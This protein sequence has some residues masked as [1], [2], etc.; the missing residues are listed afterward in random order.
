[1]IESL[2]L[3][4]ADL[5]KVFHGNAEKLLKLGQKVTAKVAA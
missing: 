2:D 1:V 5:E 4:K 3:P